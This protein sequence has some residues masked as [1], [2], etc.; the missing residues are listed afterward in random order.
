MAG[1]ARVKSSNYQ[2]LNAMYPVLIEASRELI[3]KG[4]KRW[5]KTSCSTVSDIFSLL[6][7]FT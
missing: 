2:Y 1:I 5:S 6:Y 4:A 7:N 3:K